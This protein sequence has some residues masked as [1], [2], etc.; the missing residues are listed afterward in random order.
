MA[1]VNSLVRMPDLIDLCGQNCRF[2]WF[3]KRAHALS[4][5]RLF[6]TAL[7]PHL[8]LSLEQ[9]LSGRNVADLSPHMKRAF[10]KICSVADDLQSG[11]RSKEFSALMARVFNMYINE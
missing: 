11:L 7:P 6:L 4:Q 1:I 3:R 2:S 9:S 5:L 8:I 10:L